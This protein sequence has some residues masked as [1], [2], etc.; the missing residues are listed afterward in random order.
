[1]PRM[2]SEL[3]ELRRG[4]AGTTLSGIDLKLTMTG[5]MKT[6][7]V[8]PAPKCLPFLQ[9]SSVPVVENA[10]INDCLRSSRQHALCGCANG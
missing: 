6:Y 4:R 8:L 9:F 10:S 1:M 3:Q 5:S 2:E 7:L